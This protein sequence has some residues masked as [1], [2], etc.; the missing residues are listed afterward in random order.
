M[1]ESKTP[2]FMRRALW[3]L[4]ILAAVGALGA[5]G[6]DIARRA[7]AMRPATT[8]VSSVW[9]AQPGA[10]I[11]VVARLERSEGLN[12]YSAELL[13]SRDGSTYRITPAH[14]RIALAGDTSIIMGTA[15]DLKPGAVVQA[16][17]AMDGTRTY[18][19][20]KI[21]VLTGMVRIVPD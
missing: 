21:V 12:I 8:T 15:S 16:N 3:G 9:S 6:F 7:S 4:A 18:H 1:Q 5:I 2:K 11:K 20:S 14:I 19:A 13:E 17:G 10:R